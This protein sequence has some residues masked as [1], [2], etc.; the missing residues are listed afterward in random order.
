[1]R[2]PRWACG[3]RSVT[4]LEITAGA[5]AA[6]LLRML[7]R[8]ARHPERDAAIF[9]GRDGWKTVTWG[10]V[11]SRARALAEGFASLGVQPGARVCIFAQTR[12]E[13]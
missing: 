4:K 8:R 7:L 1:M 12:F 13:W 10:E 3:V 9:K 6:N 2:L 11:L 5:D